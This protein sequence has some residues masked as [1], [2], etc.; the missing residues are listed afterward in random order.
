LNP[1]AG[2]AAVFETARAADPAARVP[3]VCRG[4]RIGSVAREHL[5]HLAAH[6]LAQGW[7]RATTAAV[8]WLGAP[9][10]L[11]P[12]L[13]A[14]HAAL[15]DEGRLLAWRGEGF[16][17]FAPPA[18][19]GRTGPA[20]LRIER[21]AARL[22][23]TLTLGAHATGH[24][25]DASGRPTA[26][27]IARRA[28]DKATDPGRLDN[29]VG[30]GVPAG[31]SPHEALLRE[32][33]E[34]AGLPRAVALAA[35]PAGVLALRRD[36]REGLQREWLHAFDLPLHADTVPRNTDGEVAGF[37]R[38]TPEEALAIA[39]TPGAMT[40]D[41]AVVTLDFLWRHGL[42]ADPAV[43]AAI[44]R[45]VSALRIPHAAVKTVPTRRG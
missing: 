45:A 28:A 37:E 11:E 24:V 42:V 34:E 17:V 40:V 4:R 20:L 35:R 41:A 31:Q 22:W 33:W 43:H 14:L 30:G 5:A 15:R 26:L 21:A 13:A 36:V 12:R 7:L 16:D 29:L 39:A 1:A 18:D 8:A 23:G 6:P 10:E 3:L 27:W 38:V 19:D 25:A 2:V 9:A 44:G 32:A